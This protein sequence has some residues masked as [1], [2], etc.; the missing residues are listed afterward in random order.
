MAGLDLFQPG[1]LQLQAV[2]LLSF[3]PPRNPLIPRLQAGLRP[4]TQAGSSS[5]WPQIPGFALKER[6]G[7]PVWGSV[8]FQLDKLQSSHVVL[9]FV[10]DREVASGEGCSAH[11][12]DYF[13]DFHHKNI[14]AGTQNWSLPA[15]EERG[16]PLLGWVLPDGSS[17]AFDLP[18]NHSR[19][20]WK[21]KW[22]FSLRVKHRTP[23]LTS[24][25]AVRGWSQQPAHSQVQESRVSCR[26]WACFRSSGAGLHTGPLGGPEVTRGSAVATGSLGR[27]W[28][29]VPRRASSSVWSCSPCLSGDLAELSSRSGLACVS[30]LYQSQQ[31]SVGAWRG[32]PA[33][34]RNT[35]RHALCSATLFPWRLT[36]IETTEQRWC[37]FVCLL[38]PFLV[39]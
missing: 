4:C 15:S 6:D 23:V 33:A 13:T 9:A 29:A 28:P 22:C 20:F 12:M 19:L 32:W 7:K 34:K 11:R 35:A 5:A 39:S 14:W 10:N 8:G 38:L 1:L 24:S 18:S 21:C 27:T 37:P 31:L 2:P 36:Y 3:P 16:P 30:S 25:P 17:L 26:Q